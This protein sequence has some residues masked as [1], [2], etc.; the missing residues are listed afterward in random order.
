MASEYSRSGGAGGQ[1]VNKFETA[2]SVFHK[3]TGLD[4]RATAGRSQ[5]QNKEK[6]IAIL[7]AKLQAIKD[8]EEAKKLS[9]D[10]KEQIG[11]SMRA[12]KI[13]TYNFPQDR[14]TDHR[15]KKS[16]S[17]LEGILAGGID[18]IIE[19]FQVESESSKG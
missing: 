15:I 19:T 7:T 14:I 3:P 17:N 18:P 9:K 11:T 4:V 12:E 8:E 6:A 2:V 1:H 5:S 16:W 10:R 13:R